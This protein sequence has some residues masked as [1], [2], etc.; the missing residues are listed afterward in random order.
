ME[1][2]L[3]TS[4]RNNQMKNVYLAQF[5]TVSVGRYFFFP[6]SVGLLWSYAQTQAEIV[7][8]YQLKKILWIKKPINEIVNSLEKPD[9]VGLSNYV[10]NVN[11]NKELAKAIK[12]EFPFCKIIMGGP[13]IPDDDDSYFD[14]HPFVDFCIHTEG[15]IN[16]SKI[17]LEINKPNPDFTNFT[18]I[19]FVNSTCSK[20]SER[21]KDINEIPSPY[22]E[23]LFDDIVEEASN[24]GYTVNMLLET[25][26]GCPFK[27]TFCDWGGLTFSKLYNF[28]IDRIKK[29]IE[30]AGK[31]RIELLSLADAN[32]GIFIDRDM[33]IARF[34][35]ETKR[36]YGYPKLFDTSWTKNTTPKTIE[37]AKTLLNGGMFRKFIMSLQTLNTDALKNIKRTNVNGTLFKSLVEDRSVS[38]AT[39]LIVGLPGETLESYKNG[40]CSLLDMKI[41]IITNPLT[42]FPNSEMSSESYRNEWELKT[43]LVKSTW[44]SHGVDEWEELVIST[45]SYSSSDWSEMLL[46]G[47]ITVFLDGYFWTDLVSANFNKRDWHDWAFKWFS[48]NDSVLKPFLEK[49]KNHFEE[50]TSYELWGGGVGVL[51]LTVNEAIL[52]DTSWSHTLKKCTQ[53]FCNFYS[54]EMPS[55]EVFEKQ[56]NNHVVLEGYTSLSEQLVS[57]RWNYLS[58]RYEPL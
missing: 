50:G 23:G 36:K 41:K 27:C 5:S 24:L 19:S 18:G 42:L 9:I 25:N 22:L 40:V 58:R 8:Q 12:N 30:W 52:Q 33:E 44:S 43:K 45:K 32:F 3:L 29:E 51:D 53:E 7:K 57:N 46:W 38:T 55:D 6:Y 13:A 56:K 1:D 16:F 14:E 37:I 11:Y 39:E 48:K 31:N 49:Y 28:N 35:V 47:W 2:V 10:W 17:L 34:A 4:P 21:I 26:R 20:K 15:E 54:V